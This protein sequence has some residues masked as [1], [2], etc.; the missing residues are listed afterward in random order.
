MPPCIAP[1]LELDREIPI[2]PAL[3][4]ELG[5]PSSV[6]LAVRGAPVKQI[7]GR[8]VGSCGLSDRRGRARRFSHMVVDRTGT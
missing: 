8:Y 7:G 4:D 3:V 5:Y 2:Q 1:Q 6:C